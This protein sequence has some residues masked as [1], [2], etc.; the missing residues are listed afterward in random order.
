MSQRWIAGLAV[1]VVLCNLAVAGQK[2]AEVEE[3]VIDTRLTPV[4]TITPEK[5][6]RLKML[7]GTSAIL[8]AKRPIDRFA[9]GDPQVISVTI[10][11]ER[12]L[13]VNAKSEGTTN[14]IV[15]EEASPP[16]AL[17]VEVT[18]P[19]K[20]EITPPAKPPKA[21]T[22]EEAENL[23]KQA[24]AGLPVEHVVLQLPDETIAIVLKENCL[25]RRRSRRLNPLPKCLRR[26]SSVC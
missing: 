8:T 17:W 2:P 24:L 22:P 19:V 13:V 25:R 26:K 16:I 15:W 9:L 11:A 5:P 18:A 4:V 3:K 1:A 10:L 6:I 7:K 21:I 20:E 23:L 14:I 12:E